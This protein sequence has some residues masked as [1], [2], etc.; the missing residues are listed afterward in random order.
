MS[1]IMP[2]TP[3]ETRQLLVEQQR[4]AAGLGGRWC[5]R[6][7]PRVRRGARLDTAAGRRPPPGFRPRLHRPAS[8]TPDRRRR[9]AGRLRPTESGSRI[10]WWVP[11]SADEIGDLARFAAADS[12]GR[13]NTSLL[14]FGE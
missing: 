10:G 1:T 12:T 14:I 6:S 4:V 3:R 9:T 11:R 7:L 5:E 8:A 13:R 2:V